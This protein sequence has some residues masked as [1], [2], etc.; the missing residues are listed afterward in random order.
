MHYYRL[1]R[2]KTSLQFI[3]LPYGSFFATLDALKVADYSLLLLSSRVEINTWGDT[4]LRTMQAQ[5][6]PTVATAISPSLMPAQPH[7]TKERSAILKSLL[8]FIQ[9]FI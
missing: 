7:S 3:L 8:S 5:G 9:Y 1:E 4:L 6:I 2:F